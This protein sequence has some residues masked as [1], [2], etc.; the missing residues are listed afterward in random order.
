MLDSWATIKVTVAE[1]REAMGAVNMYHAAKTLG[2]EPSALEAV[3]H[4]IQHKIPPNPQHFEVEGD[5]LFIG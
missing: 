4:Y 2:H 3:V 1:I 5:P